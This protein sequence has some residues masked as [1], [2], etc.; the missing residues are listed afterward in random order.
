MIERDERPLSEIAFS[1]DVYAPLSEKIVRAAFAGCGVTVGQGI[2]D[3]GCTGLLL[4]LRRS[5][6]AVAEGTLAHFGHA[7]SVNDADLIIEAQRIRASMAGSICGLP[8]YVPNHL[9][10]LV[11][12]TVGGLQVTGNKDGPQ[13]NPHPEGLALCSRELTPEEGGKLQGVQAFTQVEAAKEAVAH[14]GAEC[15]DGADSLEADIDADFRGVAANACPV[16]FPP[17]VCREHNDFTIGCRYCLAQSIVESPL[18]PSMHLFAEPARG[19]QL[20][21]REL[22]TLPALLSSTDTDVVELY[23]RAV[24]WTRRLVKE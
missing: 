20:L 3:L 11:H 1:R 24:R 15:S 8:C 14:L 13:S 22:S 9:F 18:A 6:H 10:C 4:Q 5:A 12:N 2:I 16:S 21:Q 23:V 19:T 17:F 7:K